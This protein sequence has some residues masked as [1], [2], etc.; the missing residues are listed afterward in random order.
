MLHRFIKDEYRI[1]SKVSWD[2]NR[3]PH[4]TANIDMWVNKTY[5]EHGVNICNFCQEYLN[6]FLESSDKWPDGHKI[7]REA[8]ECWLRGVLI[9]SFTYYTYDYR[10]KDNLFGIDILYKDLPKKEFIIGKKRELEAVLLFYYCAAYN[11]EEEGLK[12]WE[13]YA[14]KLL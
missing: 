14:K 9:P 8:N 6:E 7:K 4:I 5:Q 1:R 11:R 13:E 12:Y 3:L 10:Q 2:Y